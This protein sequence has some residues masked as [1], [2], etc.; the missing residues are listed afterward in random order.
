MRPPLV[1]GGRSY[2]RVP[3]SLPPVFERPPSPDLGNPQEPNDEPNDQME[4]IAPVQLNVRVLHPSRRNGAKWFKNN[5]E[6]STRVRKIIEGCFK[7]PWYSWK[8]VPIFY[9]EA[10]FSTF[11]TWFEWDASIEHLVKTNFETLAAARL[12]GMVSLA[13]SRGK[14]PDWI[15]AAHWRVMVAYWRTPIAK[16]RSE[17]AR[18][19][20]LFN[21]DGLGPHCHRSGS[22]SYAKV[23]DT[24]EANNEDS[25]FIAVMKKTHQKA[26]GTYVDEKARVIAE[27]YDELLQERMA[28]MQLFDGENSTMNPLTIEEKNKIYVQVAGISK[29]GR[30]FGLGSLQNGT[31][32]SLD[33]APIPLQST[34]EVETLTV[35]VKELE[36]ELQK[37]RNENVLVHKRLDTMEQMFQSFL[38]TSASLQSLVGQNGI[39][40]A[41]TFASIPPIG[42]SA[43]PQAFMGF[44][45]F[46]RTT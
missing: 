17:K 5:T 22:R 13:K 41:A 12:K 27:K 14:Q 40:S 18:S 11:K 33:G 46:A 25:S 28:Q 37:S 1:I 6:V 45:S 20:R 32:L 42:T 26:D 23:Q 30:V 43:S 39:N 24:L 10:W 38:G 4:E 19:S 2:G 36:T 7:G 35:R 31:S 16:E 34:G 9:K 8:K 3:N 15:L 21:R 44:R 29:H